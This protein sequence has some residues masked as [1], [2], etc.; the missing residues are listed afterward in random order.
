MPEDCDHDFGPLS[1]DSPESLWNHGECLC[2]GIPD[3]CGG[4][5]TFEDF[6]Y[7]AGQ[8]GDLLKGSSKVKIFPDFLRDAHKRS[9]TFND[10]KARLRQM[11]LQYAKLF[12]GC[13]RVMTPEGT[14]FFQSTQEVWGLID[15]S[16]SLG[17]AEHLES[18]S[19][20]DLRRGERVAHTLR[21]PIV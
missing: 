21:N 16:L 18:T 14:Q 15:T 12:S 4:P 2:L 5:K 9:S 19:E 8:K 20:A 13:L 6:P 10:A 1:M 7:E 17:A 3:S 11:G